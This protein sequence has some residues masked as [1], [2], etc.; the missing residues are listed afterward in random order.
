M[1]GT[2]TLAQQPRVVKILGVDG[3]ILPSSELGHQIIAQWW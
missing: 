1:T 3:L 2:E